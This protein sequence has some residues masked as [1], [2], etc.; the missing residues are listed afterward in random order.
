MLNYEN[1][2]K[3]N[4]IKETDLSKVTDQEIQEIEWALNHQPLK[5]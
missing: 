3:I 4:I 5:V 2:G 1:M